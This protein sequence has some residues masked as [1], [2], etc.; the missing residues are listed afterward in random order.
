MN[1]QEQGW[2]G[3]RVIMGEMRDEVICIRTGTGQILRLWRDMP[4]A[5]RA[6]LF[7][8]A[9]AEADAGDVAD[10]PRC[11]AARQRTRVA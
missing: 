11:P 9:F 8:Q 2:A 6:G 5:Q 7:E 3:S 1:G 4:P 10:L